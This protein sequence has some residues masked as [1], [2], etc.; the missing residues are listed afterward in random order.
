MTNNE[1]DYDD[2][3]FFELTVE[4]LRAK[5]RVAVEALQEINRLPYDKY[6]GSEAEEAL[7]KI[8]RW[9]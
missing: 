2:D 9:Y 4:S 8:G 6:K 1:P 7:Y 5:L 3:L